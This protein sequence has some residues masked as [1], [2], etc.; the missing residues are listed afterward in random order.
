M[1]TLEFSHVSRTY[2]VRGA[3]MLRALDDVSFTL[4]S[5]TTIALVG[6]SGSGKSTIAKILTQLE[7]PTSGTILLDGEPIPRRGRKLRRYRQQVRM[8]FQDPY[9]SLNPYH[10]IRHHLE[11][12]LRLDRVVPRAEVDS[13]VARLLERV[14]LAP[15]IADRSPHELSG[16]QRLGQFACLRLRGVA[17]VEQAGHLGG[18]PLGLLLRAGRDALSVL[19]RLTRP[20]L[21]GQRLLGGRLRLGAQL[22]GLHRGRLRP[23]TTGL[24]ERDVLAS[25][26]T[27]GRRTLEDVFLDL[28]GRTLR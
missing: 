3:G 21:G 14:R 8:V 20:S 6:Q 28:T 27:V 25:R 23:T 18:Q 4:T 22:L 26:L 24:A 13:E 16:G 12:P 11:R 7:S 17:L 9:A 2:R 19:G 10:T 15:E 1:T 5:G